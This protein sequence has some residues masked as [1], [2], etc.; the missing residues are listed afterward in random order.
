MDIPIT[1][2]LRQL[3]LLLSSDQ[4]GEVAAAASAITRIL[5]KSG[6]DW[7]ALVD[8]LVKDTPQQKRAA[9]ADHN[10]G[11]AADWRVMRDFCLARRNRL[12]ERELEFLDSLGSWRG[13]LTEKQHGWLSAIHGRLRR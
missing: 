7:H 8:G 3:L 13:D 1:P 11:A 4:P 9:H 6:A 10:D 5:Q 2:R 12:R